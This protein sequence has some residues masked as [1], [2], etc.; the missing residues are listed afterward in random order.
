[1]FNFQIE[2]IIVIAVITRSGK[3]LPKFKVFSHMALNPHVAGKSFPICCIALGSNV[4]G[5]IIPDNII[6]GRKTSCVAIP[7][8]EALLKNNPNTIPTLRLAMRSRKS[9]MKYAVK[10]PGIGASNNNGA[11]K[12]MIMLII[13]RCIITEIKLL[14]AIVHNGMCPT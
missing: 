6:D 3:T 11:L 1:M 5:N 2:T 7:I 13:N 8:F 10:L 12:N 14:I 9:D 4:T